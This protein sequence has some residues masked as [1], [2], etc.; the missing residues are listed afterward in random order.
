MHSVVLNGGFCWY[1]EDDELWSLV[2]SLD[3]IGTRHPKNNFNP[4]AVEKEDLPRILYPFQ[5]FRDIKD[6]KDEQSGLQRDTGTE[7]SGEHA[8]AAQGEAGDGGGGVDGEDDIVSRPS[9]QD[10]AA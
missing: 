7:D 10:A 3:G 5:S 1:V 4:V 9:G 2:D 8:D 6:A